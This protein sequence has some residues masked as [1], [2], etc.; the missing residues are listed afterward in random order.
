MITPARIDTAALAH[1]I[2]L[3]NFRRATGCTPSSL[4]ELASILTDHALRISAAEAAG[5]VP[6]AELDLSD[7]P[8]FGGAEPLDTLGV[9]SWDAESL[10]VGDGS[11][12]SIVP[13]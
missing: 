10:L 7:L 9:W 11:D 5:E 8:T 2:R 3:K 12:L 4:E 1:S 13:R 6:P